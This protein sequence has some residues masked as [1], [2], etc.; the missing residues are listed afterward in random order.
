MHI[1]VWLLLGT[2]EIGQFILILKLDNSSNIDDADANEGSM[3][4][5]QVA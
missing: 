2:L 1:A 3:S 4:D 5:P